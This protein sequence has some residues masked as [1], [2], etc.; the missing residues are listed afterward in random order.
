MSVRYLSRAGFAVLIACSASFAQWESD[1]A[2]LSEKVEAPAKRHISL[3]REKLYREMAASGNALYRAGSVSTWVGLGAFWGGFFT[4]QGLIS[5]LGLLAMWGGIPMM[6]V[7]SGQV[8]DAAVAINPES[9]EAGSLGWP[10][11]GAGLASQIGSFVVLVANLKEDD[12]GDLTIAPAAAIT[13]LSLL[14]AGQIMHYVSWYQFSRR[15][16]AGN[17]NLASWSI[18]PDLRV[19]GHGVQATGARLALRF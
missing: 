10:L 3:K 11:Y 19:A 8:Q 4:N 14:A 6:G 18:V 16:S 9:N 17:S 5:N 15:R 1:S 12:N 7:G 13:G 2:E